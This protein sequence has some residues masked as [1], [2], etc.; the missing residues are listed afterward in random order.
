MLDGAG[1]CGLVAGLVIGLD[2]FAAALGDLGTTCV[3]YT[4]VPGCC[5]PEAVPV[6]I[7]AGFCMPMA[8]SPKSMQMLQIVRENRNIC[9]LKYLEILLDFTPAMGR[10]AAQNIFAR[11]ISLIALCDLGRTS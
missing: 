2:D 8:E 9:V 7:W 3:R 6:R 4:G 10:T 1:L 11:L 5:P